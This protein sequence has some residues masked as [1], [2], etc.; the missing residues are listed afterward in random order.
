MALTF[1]SAC[2]ASAERE[3][4]SQTLNCRL[5][6]QLS[7]GGKSII[8]STQTTFSGINTDEPSIPPASCSMFTTL[9]NNEIS[10]NIT[11][12]D[13]DYVA[14]IYLTKKNAPSTI[15]PGDTAFTVTLEK[16]FYYRYNDTTLICTLSK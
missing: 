7:S 6:K 10:F 14:N 3:C 9:G 16:P 12:E 15:L 5:E 2:F 1:S 8:S 4:P 11:M 13:L